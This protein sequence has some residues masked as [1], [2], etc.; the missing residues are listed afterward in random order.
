MKSKKAFSTAGMIVSALIV[1]AGILAMS[2][3]FG[4]GASYVPYL[5]DSG[6]ASFGG[7]FYSYVN[8]NAALAA[9]NVRN[10]LYF[11]TTISGI[12]MICIG[13]LGVCYFGVARSECTPR[14]KKAPVSEPQEQETACAASS[15]DP[16]V[17]PTTEPTE[18]SEE[19]L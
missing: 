11:A 18:A 9:Q 15:A 19:T 6:Y 12:F 16:T 7:D 2:E 4:G 17:E 5:Y 1:I 13:L 8:N 3:V 10:L 14:T